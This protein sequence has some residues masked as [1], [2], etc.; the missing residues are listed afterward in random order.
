M[1]FA[2]ALALTIC[3]LAFAAPKGSSKYFRVAGRVMEIN[4]KARTLLVADHSSEKLYLITVPEGVTLKITFGKFMQ[5]AEPYFEDVEKNNRV[6]IRCK[7]TGEEHLARLDDG[8]IA[9]KLI[10]TR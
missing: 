2:A 6:Q 9:V 1:A 5:M 3:S 10:A 8:R 4:K 7:Q